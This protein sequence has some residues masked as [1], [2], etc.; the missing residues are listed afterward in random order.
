MIYFV[1]EEGHEEPV[2]IFHAAEKDFP[3]LFADMQDGNPHGLH[4]L[5]MR[6]GDS[7]EV[8]RLHDKYRTDHIREFWFYGESIRRDFDLYPKWV[9]VRCGLR[10]EK[11]FT[12]AHKPK[13]SDIR[14]CGG[15]VVR[16]SKVEETRKAEAS[17]DE[18]SWRPGSM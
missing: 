17:R 11:H 14:T 2:R 16:E 9:C 5:M 8:E 15:T 10:S 12:W 4:L 13:D 3:A 6:D 1:G 7:A 18:G